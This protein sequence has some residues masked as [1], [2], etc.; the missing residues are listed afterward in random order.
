M[1]EVHPPHQTAYSWRDF[2]VHIATIVLGLL[3][4]VGLEQ[5]VER[6]HEH[7]ELRMAREALDRE[8][9]SNRAKLA[10][11]ERNW[12]GDL[13]TLKNN[14]LVLNYIR[15]H[16]GTPQAA[17]P[18]DLQ[19][20]QSAFRWDHAVWDTAESKGI[21]RLMSLREANRNQAFYRLMTLMSAQSLNDWDAINVAH[22]FDL[23][24][25]DPTHLSPQQLNETIQLT[26]IALAKH[27]EFGYSFGRYANEFPELPHT[28]TWEKIDRLRPSAFDFD[29][30]GM[31]AAHKLTLDRIKEARE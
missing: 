2:F 4:A 5:M 14:L 18:G 16:P 3:I 31:A 19:W 20:H 15:H 29:P 9:Q 25:S 6:I 10:D 12:L 24:D 21:V 7:Y 23:S 22:H 11:D 8:F 13:A 27:V 1:H 28:V 30:S 17:L 26:E